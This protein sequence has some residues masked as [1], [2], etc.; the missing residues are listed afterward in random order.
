MKAVQIMALGASIATYFG[1]HTASHLLTD[2]D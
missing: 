1:R 2:R